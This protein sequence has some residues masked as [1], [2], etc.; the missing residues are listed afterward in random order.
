M[1]EKPPPVR[2][3]H[4]LFK[5]NKQDQA[6]LNININVNDIEECIVIYTLTT[7]NVNTY[8]RTA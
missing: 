8:Q 5:P 1:R 4:C 3:G 7:K 6:C 2:E